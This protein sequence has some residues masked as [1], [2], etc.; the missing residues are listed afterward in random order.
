VASA[1]SS[2]FR[3]FIRT[4]LEQE[5]LG[6]G[7]PVEIADAVV[8]NESNYNP[9]T[10][11][12]VGEIGLM[13]IRPETAAMMGFRGSNAE[14]ARPET[15]IHYGVMYLSKAWRLT[16]GDL[17]RTLM[18]YRAGHGEDFMTPR[19]VS[20]CSRAQAYLA[21]LGSPLPIDSPKAALK[22]I[23]SSS[24]EEMPERPQDVYKRYKQGSVSASQAFW[25]VQE[26][27]VRIIKAQLRSRISMR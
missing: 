27:R 8:Q 24:A 1:R 13:Q 4:L 22:P 15:N 11:G 14:L 16:S 5:V 3:S 10:I 7:L 2:Q 26:A 18:K 20:Y 12:S 25:A 19:S 6:T 17:C 21:A 23:V 9:L